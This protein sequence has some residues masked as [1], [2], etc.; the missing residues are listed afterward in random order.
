MDVD[1]LYYTT[2]DNTV[3]CRYGKILGIPSLSLGEVMINVI[4]M[5]LSYGCKR[6]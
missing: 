3:R 1:V 6:V 2:E 5:N 4:K